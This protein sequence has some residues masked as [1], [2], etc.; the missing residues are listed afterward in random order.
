MIDSDTT[1][2]VRRPVRHSQASDIHIETHEAPPTRYSGPSLPA[3]WEDDSG[4]I[5]I[6]APRKSFS[7][8]YI[9][10]VPALEDTRRIDP[11][12]V[13]KPK[14]PHDKARRPSSARESVSAE[15]GLKKTLASKRPRT[16]S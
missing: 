12:K 1:N 13:H 11:A 9:L 15:R 3:P 4:G 8:D 14:H 10:Q 5:V 7:D 6:L 2:N 16:A